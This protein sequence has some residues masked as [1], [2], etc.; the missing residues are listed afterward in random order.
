MSDE[1]HIESAHRHRDQVRWAPWHGKSPDEEAMEREEALENDAREEAEEDCWR[2]RSDVQEALFCYLFGGG[3][4]RW[5]AVALRALAVM[6]RMCPGLLV[7][8]SLPVEAE[9]AVREYYGPGGGGYVRFDLGG[10]EKL[11]NGDV[12]VV[13]KL[14]EVFFR[15]ESAWL[16]D[17][18][19]RLY[20][21]ARAYQPQLVRLGNGRDP[22]YEDLAVI[23]EEMAEDA[24]ERTRGLA[25]SRWS[26]RA[27]E[28]IR[29]PIERSG[30][31]V[32]ALFGKG[33]AVR[34]KY[35]AA[36]KGNGNRRKA[37]GDSNE[38]ARP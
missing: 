16:Q 3:A 27:Q 8:R 20:L 21:V 32:P 22:S 37:G 1:A 11:V 34:R 25:R 36:A 13:E 33:D 29:K 15:K 28:V 26:A 18:C 24:D 31:K 19:Q 12:A 5:R 35:Q 17:G 2:R 23:F 7:G 38:T 10:L 6:R 14:M 4:E 9:D 30:G